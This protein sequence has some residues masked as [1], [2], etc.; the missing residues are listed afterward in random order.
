MYSRV[1]SLPPALESVSSLPRPQHLAPRQAHERRSRSARIEGAASTHGIVWGKKWMKRASS[2]RW[3]PAA[4][5]LVALLGLLLRALPQRRGLLVLALRVGHVHLWAQS[6]PERPQ[7][8]RPQWSD[9]PPARPCDV[10]GDAPKRPRRQRGP[11]RWGPRGSGAWRAG[12]GTLEGGVRAEA[13]G[14]RA[15]NWYLRGVESFEEGEEGG[16]KKEGTGAAHGRL[17]RS[18]NCF[19]HAPCVEVC[20]SGPAVRASL[21]L[22]VC[23]SGT[24]QSVRKSGPAGRG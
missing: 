20:P 8:G 2:P 4:F 6:A 3:P 12:A 5:L 13:L 22:S 14:A 15:P 9:P 11:V 23:P 10:G 19:C 16:E 1:Y 7:A 24:G 18:L 17:S 21:T